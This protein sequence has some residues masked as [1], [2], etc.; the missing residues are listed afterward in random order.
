MP[1]Y[2]SILL[3]LPLLGLLL[4]AVLPKGR[5]ELHRWIALG[6]SIMQLGISILMAPLFNVSKTLLEI[7][8]WDNQF[9]FREEYSWINL[10]LGSLGQVK[11][12]FALGIDGLGMMLILLT[13]IILPIAVLSSW[14][15][16]KSPKA[17]F[18]LF[19]LLNLSTFGLFSA[20][21]FFLFLHFLRIHA[22]CPCFSSLVCGGEKTRN[23]R[24]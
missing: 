14:K 4:M 17:Y 11:I 23:M 9:I 18:M 16:D 8:N 20:M 12:D 15:I 19:M 3:L 2:L 6:V 24:L 13:A 10:S 21:N 1:G 5:E 7:G 22:F